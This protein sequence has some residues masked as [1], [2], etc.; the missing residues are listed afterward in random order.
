MKLKTKHL[1]QL[2]LLC[3][4][5]IGVFLIPQITYAQDSDFVIENGVLKEYKGH[6]KNVVIP[7]GV[8][9]IDMNIFGDTDQDSDFIETI[10]IPS[11]VKKLNSGDGFA[12]CFNTFW[13]PNLKKIIVS[14]G[15]SSGLVIKDP[16][17]KKFNSFCRCYD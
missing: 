1:F 7:N 5:L 3:M 9:T 11:S 13:C 10:T 14:N 16:Q 8:T 6:S 15:T 2:T 4:V 17:Q 12:S